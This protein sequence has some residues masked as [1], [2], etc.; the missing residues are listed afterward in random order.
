MDIINFLIHLLKDPLTVLQN[1]LAVYDTLTYLILAL[2]IFVE[3][4][5]IVM[6][7][8]PGDSLLFAV[9]LLASTTGKL[10]IGL[11]IPLLI[12]AALLGDN[13][14]YYVGKHFSRF[15]KSRERILFF[16]HEYL[17]Q[18]EAFYQKHGG[19]AVIIARFIP[20][21]RTVA[22]FV[23]GAGSMKYGK[24]LLYCLVGTTLWVSSI[25]MAG[26]FL[27]SNEWVKHNFE[28]VV[29]GIVFVSLMP[30]LWHVVKPRLKLS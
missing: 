12:T 8:L 4:G 23:A 13:V 26:Y 7:L 24:Y 28:K 15:V 14:N 2:I 6:P 9:G 3:T 16:K 20:I 25:T 27:G 1:F 5:L 21:V 29:L 22:P 11:V 17:E 10:D 19:K 18:T 30:V